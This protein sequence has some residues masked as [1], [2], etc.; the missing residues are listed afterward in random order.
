VY[1][2]D[3]AAESDVLQ[4][5]ADSI[6][7]HLPL[8]IQEKPVDESL[9]TK[10]KSGSD[11][12]HEDSGAREDSQ[13]KKKGKDKELTA[14]SSSPTVGA[15]P[16]SIT[17]DSSPVK[18]LTKLNTSSLEQDSKITDEIPIE[19]V[20]AN[21]SE[22]EPTEY[23]GKGFAEIKCKNGRKFKIRHHSVPAGLVTGLLAA[24]DIVPAHIA[25]DPL[26]QDELL[27]MYIDVPGLDDDLI[28]TQT[29]YENGRY[30]LEIF[31]K[32]TSKHGVGHT[33]TPTMGVGRG[34]P[35]VRFGKVSL[36]LP[37]NPSFQIDPSSF[38]RELK[39]GVLCVRYSRM[40]ARKT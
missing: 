2:V 28:D 26:P 29:I 19:V 39:D 30:F 32:R 23:K 25:Y 3:I 40:G 33:A 9:D 20:W 17:N 11:S 4:D 14:V 18:Q 35:A 31:A 6:Q 24:D 5:L 12:D 38:T 13:S 10:Q 22:G 16:T 7:R 1:L 8:Y 21:I 34:A 27:T 15:I 37:I 36:T